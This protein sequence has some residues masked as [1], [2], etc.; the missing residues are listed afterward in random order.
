MTADFSDAITEVNESKKILT[1]SYPFFVNYAF[2]T[3]FLAKVR[4]HW[5]P[6][7]TLV[8]FVDEYV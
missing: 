8:S 4:T 5:P 1:H 6:P 7:D 2:S 3:I